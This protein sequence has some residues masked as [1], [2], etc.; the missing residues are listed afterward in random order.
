[1][2]LEDEREIVAHPFAGYMEP[3]VTVNLEPREEQ[4]EEYVEE[5][6]SA[7]NQRS[8]TD[9]G[10]NDSDDRGDANF[11]DDGGGRAAT[12]SAGEGELSRLRAERGVR[13]RCRE[14]H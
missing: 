12:E 5:R 2:D 8:E 6:G 13:E 9:D 4:M 11:Y 3:R 10:G 14:L 7:G 1:M